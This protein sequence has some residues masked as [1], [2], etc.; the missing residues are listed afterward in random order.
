MTN[1]STL[2]A[3]EL[4]LGGAEHVE[5]ALALYRQ[6]EV[7][8]E[9][10]EQTAIGFAAVPDPERGGALLLWAD[11][12]GNVEHVIAY[13]LRC[14][15]AFDLQGR[16]GFVHA[17]TCDRARPGSFGGG[18]HVLDL[19]RRESVAWMDCEHWL[20]EQL[21]ALDATTTGAASPEVPAS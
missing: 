17:L 5:P 7:E 21:A 3:C 2:F 8:L 1:Y 9:H 6:L 4:P 11:E 10:D 14:A 18:A 15:E 19:G 16:W 13:V 12:S 20:A